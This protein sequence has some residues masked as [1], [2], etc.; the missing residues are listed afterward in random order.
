MAPALDPFRHWTRV[1]LRRF[2]NRRPAAR[3]RLFLEQLE[4]RQLLAADLFHSVGGVT[5]DDLNGNGTQDVGEPGIAGVTLHLWRDNGDNSLGAGDTLVASATSNGSGS[6]QFTNVATGVY[7]VEQPA[8]T[9]GVDVLR[10]SVRGPL[11]LELTS[12]AAIDTFDVT[13]QVV[14]ASTSP[15][16]SNPDFDSSPASEAI[17]GQRDLF[18]ELTSPTGRVEILVNDTSPGIVE[19]GALGTSTGTRL[20]TWDGPDGDATALDPTGLG[21]VDLTEA[22]ARQA[23]RLRIGADQDNGQAVLRVFTDANRSSEA[24]FVV[25]YTGGGADEIVL[26]A[27]ASDFVSTGSSGGADFANVGAIQFEVDGVQAIDVQLDLM[28]LVGPTAATANVANSPLRPEIR[29]EKATN[30]QDADGEP[31]PYVAAGSTVT[32][33]YVVTNPGNVALGSV[34]VNDDQGVTVTFTGGDTNG[35][36]LLDITETWTFQATGT[37]TAGQYA[38]LATATGNP[39][40][41][42]GSDIPGLENV[43][44]TDPSHYF[45]VQAAVNL[46]KATNGQDADVPTGPLVSPGDVVTWIYVVTNT[47]NVPLGD[48]QVTDNRGVAVSFVNGD[49]NGNGLLD[50][51]ETWT[52]Q[53]TGTATAGQYSNVGTVVGNPVLP[54]GTDIAGVPNV[55]DSDPSHYFGVV[56]GVRIEKATNG[57]DADVAPGPS[58]FV[59][60]TVTWTYAVSNTGNVALTNI[61]VTD[62]NGTATNPADDFS[63]TYVGG[64]SNG[65]GQLDTNETWTFTASRPVL[66]GAYRNE[67]TV[68]ARGPRQ[69]LTSATDP[70]NYLGLAIFSKRRFLASSLDRLVP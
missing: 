25:P 33:T 44:D 13:T 1:L 3:K 45:G 41:D 62:D 60:Q 21:G 35:N 24:T 5:F 36:G 6:Y 23:I 29:V 58:L 4:P 26:L 69:E 63:P 55:T 66:E 19:F 34:Q 52:Y 37:A 22:G 9:V 57:H 48:V 65:N 51:T 42:D 2:R 8:Q 53:G 46:E 67:A 39:V 61:V 68:T 20:I 14:V 50:L 12:G 38:N 47:G 31:G 7:F 56:V 49:T 28:N 64:D 70:S 59:G 18:V 32:W 15:S 27:Y 10:R 16:N 17:G 54:D 11:T 40:E 30:G 43:T